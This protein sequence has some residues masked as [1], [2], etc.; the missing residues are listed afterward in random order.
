MGFP[1]T[2][3]NVLPQDGEYLACS[4]WVLC[5]HCPSNSNPEAFDIIQSDP[6][7]SD[8]EKQIAETLIPAAVHARTGALLFD[9][10]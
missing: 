7:L 9:T 6:H 5:R 2:L 10:T 4:L 1:M 3:W 8:A